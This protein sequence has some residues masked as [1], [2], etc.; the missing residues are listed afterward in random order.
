MLARQ[1]RYVIGHKILFLLFAFVFILSY[2]SIEA[3]DT[4]NRKGKRNGLSDHTQQC[5][6]LVISGRLSSYDAYRG[7]RLVRGLP[8]GP[9]KP[10]SIK[11][12]ESQPRPITRSL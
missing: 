10:E 3:N 12:L 2:T 7:N 9:D 5:D 1:A 6:K 11:G 8:D 4:D